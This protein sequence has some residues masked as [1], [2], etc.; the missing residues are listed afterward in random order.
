VQR[1]Y[2]KEEKTFQKFRENERELRKQIILDSTLN[3]FEKKTLG[4]TS[5]ADIAKEVGVSTSTLYSY[6]PSQEELF[7]EAF[8]RDL[9]HI[10]TMM[11]EGMASDIENAD[12][13]AMETLAERILNHLLNSEATFQ[14]ISLLITE[15]SM[16]EHILEKFNYFRNEFHERIINVLKISGVKNP[17][18]TT[19][20]AFFASVLGAI[21]I[22]RNHPDLD[23][24]NPGETVKELVGYIVKVFKVGIPV[25]ETMKKTV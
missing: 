6:F 15:S 12:Q 2:L 25:L 17:D 24:N 10:D 4:K 11:E 20:R 1:G 14:M 16:P 21:M 9:S 23:K 18:V 5:M 7:L 8:L 3:L 13:Q 19:S 22:F